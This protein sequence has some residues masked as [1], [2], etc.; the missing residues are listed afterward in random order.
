MLVFTLFSHG[1][2]IVSYHIIKGLTNARVN[3]KE[4]PLRAAGQ[5]ISSYNLIRQVFMLLATIGLD[6][7]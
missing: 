7:S 4:K 3:Q 5:D 6:I 2:F 1:V